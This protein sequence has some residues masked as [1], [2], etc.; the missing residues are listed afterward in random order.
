[1]APTH[2]RP[3]AALVAAAVCCASAASIPLIYLVVRVAGAG[4]DSV[5]A[6][7]TRPRLLELLRNSLVLS[8]SVT[9]AAVL[10]GVPTAW[11]LARVRLRG[12]RVWAAIAAIPLAVP[13][14]VA[15]YG[16][17]AAFPSMSGFWAA[18]FVLTLVGVPYV[19][20]PTVAALNAASADR[21]DV[22]R[23]LGRG[24]L[25]AF[26]VGTLPQIRP[27]VLAGALLVCLYTLSDFGGLALFR[28]PV[29]TTAIF[30]A[31]STSFDRD[32]AAVLSSV[33]ILVALAVVVVEQWMRRRA[34]GVA[35]GSGRV[36]RVSP[37]RLA[38]IAGAWLLA[39]PV[40]AAGVPA[41]ALIVRWVQA[42]QTQAVD[43][44]RF[45]DAVLATAT[46]AGAGAVVALLLALPIGVLSARWHGRTV[47][48]IDA[49]GTLPLGVPGIVVG[50]SLVFASLA[51]VP[52]WYQSIG[53]LSFAYGVL[54]VPKAIGGVR[55]AI[56]QVPTGLEEVARTLGSGRVAVW[57]RVTAPLAAPGIAGAALLVAVTAMKELPAT[58][59]LRPTGTNT[60]ATELW[61]HTEVNAYGSA[62]PYA[63]ALLVAAAI[64]ALLLSRVGARDD[65][66]LIR[67]GVAS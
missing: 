36:G 39:V 16:W 25:G 67:D 11:M 51:L 41:I 19:V 14:Y 10:I 12:I 8:L 57:R 27:A 21:D 37:G 49:L 59:L 7:L 64:P 38:P 9:L 56:D 20:L 47:Q 55:S 26:L 29:L 53:V 1:M 22:A 2:R 34:H 50:L 5:L 33:L 28:F 60:L 54:F 66:P 44:R 3:P 63:L 58:L 52:Q 15:A 4:P 48:T 18:W 43:P 13:S 40:L 30:R 17:L 62:A 6:T 65:A 32:Y 23:T 46:L 45:L 31:Y 61:S 35:T 24:P 42:D